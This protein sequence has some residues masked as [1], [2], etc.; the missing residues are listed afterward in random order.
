MFFIKQ[1]DAEEGSIL[2]TKDFKPKKEG[3]VFQARSGGIFRV[4]KLIYGNGSNGEMFTV[5]VPGFGQHVNS[6]LHVIVVHH[7][8]PRGLQVYFNFVAQDDTETVKPD[9]AVVSSAMRMVIGRAD[10]T[11]LPVR[12]RFAA[13]TM[14]F[15]ELVLYDR[16]LSKEEVEIVHLQYR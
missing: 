15:D 8:D 9:L 5:T 11:H 13:K 6:W 3:F 1:L 10:V 14:V 7:T 2:A 4:N 16:P 12:S